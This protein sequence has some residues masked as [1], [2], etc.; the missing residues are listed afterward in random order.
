MRG[1]RCGALLAGLCL[2]A[3]GTS[4]PHVECELETVAANQIGTATVLDCGNVSRTD[5]DA[6]LR[7]AHD[8][9][10]AAI[11]AHQPF[12]VVWRRQGID[13]APADGYLG[14]LDPDAGWTETALWY[15]SYSGGASYDPTTMIV[16]CSDITDLGPCSKD[17]L[18]AELCLRCVATGARTSCPPRP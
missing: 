6:A 7:A 9:A 17:R 8:C 18:Y 16:P 3:C 12:L 2:G 5:D 4:G 10:A 15:D 13:S 1:A 14:L 11:A